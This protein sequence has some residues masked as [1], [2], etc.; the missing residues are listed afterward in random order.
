MVLAESKGFSGG[1][2][3]SWVQAGVVCPAKGGL[4]LYIICDKAVTPPSSVAHQ[5]GTFS[6]FFLLLQ[7]LKTRC[8]SRAGV[9]SGDVFYCHLEL[10]T[11]DEVVLEFLTVLLCDVPLVLAMI[12]PFGMASIWMILIS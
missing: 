9:T 5:V 7:D 2:R 3:T 4:P 6:S 10:K 11:V 12:T 1:P 8:P